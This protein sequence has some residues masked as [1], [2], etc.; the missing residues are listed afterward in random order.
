MQV[1]TGV[2]ETGDRIFDASM[3]KENVDVAKEGVKGQ[4]RTFRHRFLFDAS[5]HFNVV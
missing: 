1:L 2:M 5:Q 3:A 4:N